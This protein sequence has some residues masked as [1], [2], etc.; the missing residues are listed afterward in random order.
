M[1]TFLEI[2][3]SKFTPTDGRGAWVREGIDYSWRYEFTPDATDLIG[4]DA[5]RSLDHWAIAAGCEAIRQRLVVLGYLVAP[6]PANAGVFTKSVRSAV[7]RFQEAHGLETDGTVGRYDARAL[8]TPLI[9]AA[10]KKHSI[11]T[12]LL[13]GETNA[14]SALD[15]GAVGFY[16]YYPKKDANGDIILDSDGKPVL[17]YR[18]VDR[19]LSQI[20]SL[21]NPDI[22]WRQAYDPTFSIDW[23]GNRLRTFYRK[24]RNDYPNATVTTLWDAALCAHNN[25]SAARLWAKLGVAPTEAAALYVAN[26]KKAIY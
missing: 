17:D 2:D 25:P 6:N 3:P 1:T 24:F 16:I 21:A 26:V 13:R 20:N 9:D 5:D 22:T 4:R 12:G 14:E 8:F 19:G 11:P 18:G 15:P 23:S 7:K 10:E